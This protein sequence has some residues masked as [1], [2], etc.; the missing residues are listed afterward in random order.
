MLDRTVLL[1]ASFAVLAVGWL[2]ILAWHG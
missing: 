1:L 2:M